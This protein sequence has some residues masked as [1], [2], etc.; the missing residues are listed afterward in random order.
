M[1]KLRQVS[2]ELVRDAPGMFYT[3]SGE[4]PGAWVSGDGR[5]VG[6]LGVTDTWTSTE[7]SITVSSVRTRTKYI[8]EQPKYEVEA[9]RPS[10]R[11]GRGL[12]RLARRRA[13]CQL[14]VTSLL[15]MGK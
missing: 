14:P 5:G 15:E 3:T 4:L 10:G 8:G 7:P 6:Y 1:S 9:V 12:A 13:P 11:S 2:R